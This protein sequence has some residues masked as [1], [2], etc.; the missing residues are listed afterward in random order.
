MYTERVK[1]SCG[2]NVENDPKPLEEDRLSH[3]PDHLIYHIF[4]FLPTF[5]IT[6]MSRLSRR[7]RR[8]WVSTPFLYFEDRDIT[9]HNKVNKQNMFLKF[10]GNCLRARNAFMQ[11]PDTSM[12]SF[13]LQTHYKFR[14]NDVRR[15][16]NWIAFAIL[17]KVKEL[18][19]DSEHYGLPLCVLNASSL[20][21]LR[22]TYLRLEVPFLSTLTSLK[23]LSL[24][25]VIF[26]D[27]SLQNLISG[28]PIIEDLHLEGFTLGDIDL[29]VSKT[30]RNLSLRNVNCTDQWLKG[31]ISGL[32]VLASL[33]LY[34]NG[35]NN[36]SIHSNSLKSLFFHASARIEVTLR[37]PNLV[38]LDLACYSN[39]IFSIEAPTLTEA[40]LT[41]GD[42]SMKKSEFYQLVSFLSNLSSLKNM[43]LSVFSEQVP[44]VSSIFRYLF[45][46]YHNA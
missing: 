34:D 1:R 36:V 31:L 46:H 9:F 23:V 26:D 22:L 30:L 18:D 2:G 20:T 40:S 45:Y 4:S 14:P 41:L 11:I 21:L 12:I 6:R 8:M 3:L 16:D 19:L 24:E 10:V 5:Y 17:C 25:R 15:I 13:K 42:I 32:P 44:S 43:K 35:M 7:W 37:T 29:A 28:C 33:T 38:C 27:K 39:S